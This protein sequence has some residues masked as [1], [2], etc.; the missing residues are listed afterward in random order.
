MPAPAASAPSAPSDLAWR[1]V[2]LLNLYRLLVPVVLLAMLWTGSPR[3]AL[4]PAEPGLFLS[5]CVAYFT[6]ALLLV[7]ARR[8]HWSSLR[9]VAIVN[10]SVDAVAIALI[11]YAS[12]GVSSGLGI[13][14][15][16]PVLA[17]ALLANHRDALLIA[18]VAA[19]AVLV[20]Q[21]FVGLEDAASS[22]DYTTA[23]VLGLVLFGMALLAWPIANRLRES[24]ALVRR[25]EVDLANLAQLSQYIVQ[26]LRESILVV[27]P[28]DC[29]RLI[30]ESAAQMLGDTSAYPGALLGGEGGPP[31]HPPQKW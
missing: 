25:Q 21:I 6:A 14:L 7:V 22:T 9:I 26:H 4:A 24:E 17:M 19:L 27:D 12:G 31:S 5:A 29:I 15:V 16:L 11:L 30:N 2:G 20:Q 10:A 1:V 23:G 13:L 18:S 28:Q 3:W 8:L